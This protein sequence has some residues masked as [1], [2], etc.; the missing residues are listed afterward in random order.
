MFGR[1]APNVVLHT[2]DGGMMCTAIELADLVSS[3]NAEE[4]AFIVGFLGKKVFSHP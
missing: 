4:S 2:E 3:M 1:R